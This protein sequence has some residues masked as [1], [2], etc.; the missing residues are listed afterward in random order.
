MT[1]T[2]ATARVNLEDTALSDI[3]QTQKDKHWAIPLPEVPGGVGS[4]E[5]E[6]R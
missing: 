1:L 6:G 3:S 4:I 5:I 2:S